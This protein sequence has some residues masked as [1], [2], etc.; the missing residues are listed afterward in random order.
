MT[1]GENQTPMEITLYPRYLICRLFVHGRS[2]FFKAGYKLLYPEYSRHGMTPWQHYVL[3]G[4]RKGYDNGCHPSD[5]V[6]FPDGYEL[7]YPDVRASGAEPWRHFAETGHAEGRDNG[8]HPNKKLFFA[9]GYI[10]MYPDVAEAGLDPW[11]H[12]VLKGRKEG[13]DNGLHPVDSQFFAEGYKEMYPDIAKPGED[14]WRHYVLEGKNDGLDNGLHPDECQFFAAGYLEMYPDVAE[15]GADPWRHYVLEGKREGRD[16]GLHPGDS[17]FF[18]AGYLEMYPDVASA[19]EDP[20]HHYVLR[21]KNEGRGNGLHPDDSQFFAEG[22]VEMYPDVAAAG[23]DPWRHYVLAGKREGRDNGLHPCGSQFFGEGYLEMYP[24]IAAAGEDP[25][26]HYVLSGKKEGLDNGLHPDVSQF[27]AAGYLG[28]YPDVGRAGFEPWHHYVLHGKKEG[29]CNGLNIYSSETGIRETVRKKNPLVAVVMPTYNRKDTVMNAIASVL[30][31]TWPNWH[32]YVVDDFSD[33]GTYEYLQSAVTDPRIV[34]LR[35]ENKGQCGARNTALR[36]I[37]KE[38]YVAY[39]DS[40]NTWNR[41]YL[42]LMLCRLTET[43]TCCCYAVQRLFQ[44]KKDGSVG[45]ISFRYDK[46]DISQLRLSNFIDINV[47]MHRSALLKETGLFDE[48]LHRVEDWDLI[49]SFA[50]RYSFSMLPYI[51][52]N[53]D[54]TKDE[55]RVTPVNGRV[56]ECNIV[57]SKHWLDWE[58]ISEEAARNDVPLVSVIIYFGRDDSVSTLENCLRSLKNA[59]LNGNSKYRT[60]III[61]DDSC[62]ESVHD[63]LSGFCNKSLADKYL[64]SP[65]FCSF[66][67]SCN[68]AL[69][70]ADGSFIVYLDSHCYVAPEWLDTLIDPLKRHPGLK[71]TCSRILRPDGVIH[72]AGC[73]IDPF[74]GLPY[75]AMRGFPMD[76]AASGRLTLLPCVNSYCC[77]FRKRDVAAV[78]GL[79]CVYESRFAISDLCMRLA[80]G[81]L[82]FAYIPS[83]SVILADDRCLAAE[84][85]SDF[86]YFEERWHGMDAYGDEKFYERRHLGQPVR[87]RKICSVSYKKYSKTSCTRCSAD[88]FVPV[89]D[90]PMGQ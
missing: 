27:F 82:C 59:R 50:E 14:P 74:S 66:P 17:Q 83:S 41:E 38:D 75:D 19:G 76:F 9:E 77:A 32:L 20:W 35:S 39:L 71:G 53:Y 12:Y 15:A 22:Y 84:R 65:I 34:L 46:L 60:E 24:D 8:L 62:S 28:M 45:T 5:S 29:R 36:H 26:H 43:G 33:D 64:A 11:R 88:Y 67:L 37:E 2:S 51:A 44:R 80:D 25:W 87:R 42:E 54:D 47:F 69:G 58:L 23:V 10:E 73:Q 61:A 16:N 63:I 52:C 21:G 31:Q 18:A 3:D 48:S 81:R 6:F 40:D 7:E 13:R 78:K 85:I 49:L 1:G 70:S 55:G 4:K 90:F 79:Y 30:G 68:M 72:S 89:F 57:R 86:A 56:P